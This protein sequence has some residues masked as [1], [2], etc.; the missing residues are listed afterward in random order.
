MFDTLVLAVDGSPSSEAAVTTAM[1]FAKKTGARVEV[2]HVH[3]HER[4]V[5]KAGTGPDLETPDE[6]T[7][8]L[9][10]VV[11]KLTAAG[12]ATHGT[13]RQAQPHDVAREIIA[14]ADDAKADCIAVGSRGLSGFSES[15]LGS[16]SNALVR[17]AE[18]PVLITHHHDHGK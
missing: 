9:S 17:H 2:V 10:S 11:D 6:A 13:L 3:E 18:R 12:V 8:L 1:E 15:L 14:V 7:T 16:V 4:I 5:S